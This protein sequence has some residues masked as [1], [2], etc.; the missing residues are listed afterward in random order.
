MN[1]LNKIIFINSANIPYN[2]MLLDGNVHLSG[3]QG[4]GKTTVIRAVLFFFTADKMR[5]G[6]ESGKRS[7]EDFYF[8][9]SNSYIIYE[10]KTDSNAFSVVAMRSQGKI[11]YRFIDSPFSRHWFVR[12][13]GRAESEWSRIRENVGESIEISPKVDTYQ[14]FRDIIYG[15]L[16]DRNH[17]FD[18]YAL[19][20]CRNYQN[21]PQS[22]Q[23]V[24]LNSKLDAEFIKD[25]IIQSM[26]DMS[27]PINLSNYR[28]HLAGFKDEFEDV[29]KW[30]S[31]KKEGQTEVREQAKAVMDAY[32]ELSNLEY[33]V[34]KLWHQLNY[35]VRVSS[36]RIPYLNDEI[37]RLEGHIRECELNLR[38][39]DDE[40]KTQHDE[41]TRNI[42]GL[43]GKLKEIRLARKKYEDMGIVNII[44]EYEEK[45]LWTNRLQQKQFLLNTLQRSFAD[46]TER[47]NALYKALDEEVE[48]VK[49]SY[50]KRRNS[51]RADFMTE[52]QKAREDYHHLQ[53]SIDKTYGEFIDSS[54]KRLAVLYEDKVN[55]SLSLSELTSWKPLSVKIDNCI[56]EIKRLHDDEFEC[57][58]K[59]NNLEKERELLNRQMEM[60]VSNL[61]G[62]TESRLSAIRQDIEQLNAR[63]EDVHDRLQNYDGSLYQ[64]LEANRPGWKENIGK[65][66][67]EKVL[68]AH[69]LEPRYGVDNGLYGVEINLDVLDVQ[70]ISIEEYVDLQDSLNKEI[71]AKKSSLAV[72]EVEYKEQ[73][74]IL[75]KHY[76]ELLAA[77]EAEISKMA[78]QVELLPQKI[79]DVETS[80][81]KLEAEQTSMVESERNKRQQLLHYAE[82]KLD[83]EFKSRT[84]KEEKRDKETKSAKSSLDKVLREIIR[85]EKAL[86][87][88]IDDECG[89]ELKSL[90]NRRLALKSDERDA[91][92]AGGADT[93]AIDDCNKDIERIN[94][95]LEKISRL[96]KTVFAYQKDE[97]DM[98]SHESEYKESRKRLK[99]KDEELIF[100]FEKKKGQVR[101]EMSDATQ[102]LVS[103]K[104]SLKGINQDLELMT[105]C[106]TWRKKCRLSYPTIRVKRNVEFPAPISYRRFALQ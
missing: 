94:K 16:R 25:T 77:N 93:K 27:E 10:V 104:D 35:C 8:P 76:K 1:R 48:S 22:I 89:A 19:A 70:Y 20:V 85:R 12:P 3:N 39:L 96:E 88:E 61:E 81:R 37:A 90:D 41:L 59:K 73:C 7:F 101:K 23:N 79:K 15:D 46:I 5:L 58:A 78:Y 75:N 100:K 53:I 40:F 83:E 24:F 97:A 28:R 31:K 2:E 99:E 42:G 92:V 64:S 71:A 6:I 68:Y 45:P 18:K 60:E 14:M 95:A 84:A 66:V 49:L 86:L 102:I 38:G 11:V 54:N 72:I 13:D 47:F 57:K 44:K 30:F 67:A 105:S 56:Q 26:P 82:L 55:C 4:S 80:Q 69:G 62:A 50:D 65:V 52:E 91:L 36:E 32:S 63:L 43:D 21:I 98:F 17:R 103:R 106:A 29:D 74:R 51:L 34:R 33:E 87:S 9:F